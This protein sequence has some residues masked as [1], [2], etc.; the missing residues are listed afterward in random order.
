MLLYEKGIFKE[1]GGRGFSRAPKTIATNINQLFYRISPDSI[2]TSA[3]YPAFCELAYWSGKKEFARLL[4]EHPGET[5][6]L[7]IGHN[8]EY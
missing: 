5:I 7:E 6:T 2:L 8:E 1:P 3:L 4:D